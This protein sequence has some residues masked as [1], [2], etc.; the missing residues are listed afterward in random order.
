MKL[1]RLRNKK[2]FKTISNRYL[3]IGILFIVWMTFFDTNSYLIQRELNKELKSLDQNTEYYSNEI[4][5]D[6]EFIEGMNDLDEIEK[7]AREKY[8]LK[9]ENEEIFLIE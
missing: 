2:W 7:Y 9:K 8:F 5:K 3:L 6:L 4:E 1:S